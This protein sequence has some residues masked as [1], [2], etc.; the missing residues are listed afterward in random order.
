MISYGTGWLDPAN[1]QREK[2][3]PSGWRGLDWA[4]N[5]PDL[6]TGDAARTQSIDIITDFEDQGLD[7]RRF[8]F[9]LEKD[10]PADA[11]ADRQTYD[12]MIK[13]GDALG[14]ALIDNRYA[15]NADPQIDPE[16]I[17]DVMDRYRKA[18]K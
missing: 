9:P 4:R 11:F 10:L 3:K 18:R 1:Y 7:F 16:R 12:Q 14:Q 2:G 6:L 13:I 15:P 8:Q 17:W 5:A